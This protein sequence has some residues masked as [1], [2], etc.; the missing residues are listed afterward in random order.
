MGLLKFQKYQK[1]KRKLVSNLQK[2]LGQKNFYQKLIKI[3]PKVRIIINSNDF[4]RSIRAYEVKKYTKKSLVEWYK[5]TKPF[6][7][8][9][10]FIKIYLGCPRNLL[11][12]RIKLR[13]E[14]MLP[15]G[16]KEV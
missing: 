10:N 7:P 11:L 9:E 13:A 4:Q 15:D 8:K 14:K 12:N 6:F 2:K 1:K 5:D 3:D 16:I